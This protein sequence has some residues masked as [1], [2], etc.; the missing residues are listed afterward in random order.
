MFLVK[1]FVQF[2][3]FFRGL[4]ESLLSGGGDA[5]EPGRAPSCLTGKGFEQA[6]AFHSVKKRIKRAG[7]NPVA[8]MREFLHHRQ[9]EDRFVARVQ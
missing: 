7:T 5:V 3:N 6:S 9:P 8:V 1:L 2:V 4:F